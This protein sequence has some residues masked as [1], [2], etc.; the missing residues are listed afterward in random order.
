MYSV[1]VDVFLYYCLLT[2]W[3]SSLALLSSSRMSMGRGS[4]KPL[5]LPGSTLSGDSLC[6]WSAS[7]FTI[8]EG[9]ETSKL[10]FLLLNLY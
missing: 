2:L 10:L 7:C 6:A 4:A 5:A 8:L 9:S 1:Q 3:Y